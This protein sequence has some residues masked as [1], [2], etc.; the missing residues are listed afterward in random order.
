[1]TREYAAL[2]GGEV[3]YDLYCGTGS[4]GIFCSAGVRKLVGVEV[5]SEAIDDARINAEINNV[6]NAEF[7]AGDVVDICDDVF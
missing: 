2:S 1:V 6:R 3:L 5:I 4:I 7:H